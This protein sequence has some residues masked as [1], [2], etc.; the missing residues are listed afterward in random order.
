MEIP[1]AEKQLVQF[2]GEEYIRY[3]CQLESEPRARLILSR[4]KGLDKS[5][6]HIGS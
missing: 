2:A 3:E 4:D 1:C 5:C 6:T